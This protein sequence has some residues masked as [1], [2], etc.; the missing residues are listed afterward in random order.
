MLPASLD[1]EKY[2]QYTW[3]VAIYLGITWYDLIQGLIN[4]S[5]IIPLMYPESKNK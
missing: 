1:R 5:C 4:K 3:R 2:L